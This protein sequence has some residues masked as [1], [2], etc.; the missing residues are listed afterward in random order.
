[1]RIDVFTDTGLADLDRIKSN[2]TGKI[3]R[4]LEGI[5]AYVV[6]SVIENF[7]TGGRPEKW[8]PLAPATLAR[9]NGTMTLIYAGL[10][11]AGIM[12]WVAGD[13][14]YVGPCGPAKPYARIQNE[15]GETG[16][17]GNTII[18]ARPYLLLQVEDH[19][20]IRDFI[21]GGIFEK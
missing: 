14:A 17:D 3:P 18:P 20:F 12:S 4:I 7:E 13:S 2:L 15:G 11:K 21:R 8:T 19:E 1:M 5:G 9:K 16:R 10:L 6:S